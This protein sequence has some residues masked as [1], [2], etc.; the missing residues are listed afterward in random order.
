MTD[1]RP[2]SL[3]SINAARER[4]KNTSLRTP[5]I[6]FKQD[7]S[8]TEIYLKLENLQPVG[9]FKI[10][11]A[12]NA[13]LRLEKSQL[14]QGVW[15]ASAGNMAYALAWYAQRL[16]IP[17]SAVVPI[18]TPSSKIKA[19]QQLGGQIV[20]VPFEDYL[21]I[22]CDHNYPG[23]IGRFIHPFG[24]DDVLAGNGTIGLEILEDL[25]GVD[26]VIVPYGGGGLS[27]GI[28]SAIRAKSSRVKVYAAEVNIAAPLASSLSAGK[29]IDV[30]Y[31]SS[32]ISGMG[33]PFIFPEMWTLA[34]DLLDGS[35]VVEISQV[36]AAIRIMAEQNHII[37]EGAGG[38]AL[39]AAMVGK[40][41]YGKIVCI[42]SGGNIDQK[43]LIKIL[44]GE[45]P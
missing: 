37:S 18:E 11:G 32:F 31:I 9:S 43:I 10:R 14:I 40:A 38:V 25:P 44:Q 6:K 42:V 7:Y 26:A 30:S 4:I 19:I 33:A 22:Q 28:A 1:H 35:L 17:C 16:H 3:D 21:R 34:Q 41:G 39:A 45:I 20:K 2:I 13:I 27:C 24:D 12:G 23:M 8:Q 29:P 5:L 15:T 36:A